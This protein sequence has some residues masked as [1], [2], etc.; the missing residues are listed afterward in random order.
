M[1]KVTYQTKPTSVLEKLKHQQ[2]QL[3]ARIQA[4]E[5]RA[6]E[7]ERKKE[8]RRKILVGAYYL[9]KARVSSENFDKLKQDMDEYLTRNSDRALFDLALIKEPDTSV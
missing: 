4:H 2:A 8:T 6:K 1:T 7:Q 9:D 5:A 3:T